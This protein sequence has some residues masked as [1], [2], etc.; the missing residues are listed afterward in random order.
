[1]KE[2]PAQPHRIHQRA[3]ITT[4]AFAAAALL[5]A[6]GVSHADTLYVSNFGYYNIE[7]FT[8][9]GVGSVFAGTSPYPYGVAFD[10]A[11]NLY[12]AASGGIQDHAQWR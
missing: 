2:E 11:G 6:P 9:G 7:E 5:A 4:L 10:S 1:M 12:V 8:A 3:S